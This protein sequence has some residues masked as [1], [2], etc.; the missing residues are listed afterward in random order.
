MMHIHCGWGNRLVDALAKQAATAA[1]CPEQVSAV[2]DDIARCVRYSLARLGAVTLA[3]NECS[4]THGESEGEARR[5]SRPNK[6]HRVGAALVEVSVQERSEANHTGEEGRKK[7][8]RGTGVVRPEGGGNVKRKLTAQANARKYRRRC[9]VRRA[10]V[11]AAAISEASV[12]ELVK[13][14]RKDAHG[15]VD[16]TDITARNDRLSPSIKRRRYGHD[17]CGATSSVDKS[18]QDDPGNDRFLA[19]RLRAR[20]RQL[21]ADRL[22]AMRRCH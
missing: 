7:G 16:G 5:D 21:A 3:A 6:R 13:R 4:V 8:P 14:A 20:E 1:G 2:V 12:L 11:A 18:Q 19:L 10:L 22:S 17:A 9:G 15:D